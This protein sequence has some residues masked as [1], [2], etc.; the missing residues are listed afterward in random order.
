MNN[1]TTLHTVQVRSGSTCYRVRPLPTNPTTFMAEISGPD[2]WEAL[3]MKGETI[4]RAMEVIGLHIDAT[5]K[6]LS[7]VA[8]LLEGVFMKHF[9]KPDV[10]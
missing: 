7:F 3:H 10:E 4:T 9:A 2:G 8:P 1:I 5:N 6:T